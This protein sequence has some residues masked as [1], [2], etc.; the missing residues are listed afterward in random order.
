MGLGAPSFFKI[1]EKCYFKISKRIDYFACT[2]F[3]D[4]Y[5][6]KFEEN[7]DCI[8]ATRK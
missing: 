5:S 8:E 3:V 6:C 2:Y 4:T 1:E 7:Y